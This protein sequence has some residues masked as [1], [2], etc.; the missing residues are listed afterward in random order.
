V[1]AR[2]A[3]PDGGLLRLQLENVELTRHHARAFPY[4]VVPGPYVRMVVSDTGLGM[5]EETRSR[6]F[7]PFF[8]TKGTGQ[9][10]GLGLA[11]V[12]GIVKQS[13]GYIWVRSEP[14]RGADFEV[15]LP[16][17][18]KELP[19]EASAATDA[20][21]EAGGSETV[22]LVED[23]DAVRKL[24]RRVLERRGYHVL[25]AASPS[26]AL[27][28]IIPAHDGP[29]HLLVTD[30]VMPEMDGHELAVRVAALYPAI[31]TIFMSGYTEDEVVRRGIVTGSNLF[32]QKPFGPPDLT[33]CVRQILDRR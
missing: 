16:R 22:L 19:E 10:T 12:F 9:G 29:I 5:D 3:M 32:L 15:L 4:D 13:G 25:E 6:V 20:D 28:G 21:P 1:N 17:V 11:T 24:S 2:D 23:D 14:G 18:E 27:L 26:D 33:R 31:R 7:E 30:V 8:T